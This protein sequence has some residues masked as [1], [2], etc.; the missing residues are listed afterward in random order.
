MQ[1]LVRISALVAAI[2]I[3]IIFGA[4]LDAQVSSSSGAIRG[5]VQ[6][7]NGNVIANAS[8]TLRNAQLSLT[9]EVKTDRDGT[10]AFPYL[11]PT[12][13]YRIT[14]EAP[15][16][17]RVQIDSLSARVTETT[18]A[19]VRLALGTVSEEVKVSATT[20]VVDTTSSTLGTVVNSRVITALP[21]PTRNV[22]D[23]LATDAGVTAALTS[24]A[25]TI[26]TSS[27]AI[28]VGGSRAT[29]NNFLF[30]GVDANSVEFNTLA[31]GTIAIP[32]ADS[33]QEFKTQTSLYDA[34]T[35]YSGGGNLNIVTRAGTKQHHGTVY[36]FLRNT[37]F[38][39][40]DYFLNA[41]NKPRPLLIQNQFGASAGGPI[42]HGHETFF[43]VNYEGLRQKN[44]VTGSVTGSQPV[45]PSTRDATSLA[46][47][48]GL[49]KSAIDPVAVNILNAQGPYGGYL[50]PSGTGSAVGTLGTYAYSSPVISNADQTSVRLD[51]EF[52]LGAQ[53][54]RLWGAFFYNKGLY[55]NP[56]GASG[57]LG[58]GYDYPLGNQNL[59]IN[60]T[61]VFSAH[62]VNDLVLGYTR[63]QRDIANYGTGVNVQDVGMYRANQSVFSLLPALS[64]TNALSLSGTTVGRYQRTANYDFRDTLSWLV[65]HHTLRIGGE[66]IHSQYNE[67][68]VP[69]TPL[70]TLAFSIGIANS[71]YGTSPLG[72]AGDLA[73]RDF[74]I[75][76][77]SSISSVSG[78]P[79]Y[80][81]RFSNYVGFV[82]DD[83]QAG[84]RLTLNLGVRYDHLGN[85]YET[86]NRFSNFDPSLLSASAAA[87]GGDSLKSAFVLAG[88]NGV[89][90]STYTAANHGSVSPR[91]GLVYDAYGD[92]Q[93]IVRAGFG[94]YY[95]A[96]TDAQTYMI[97]NPPYY[98][99]ATS[100]NTTR[101][102]IL[103]NP[104]QSLPT[105][106]QFPI[107]PTLPSI[108][109][110]SSSGVPIYSGTQIAAFS[111]DRRAKTPYTENWNFAVQ[112]RVLPQWYLEVG[113]RGANGV[114]QTNLSFNNNALL[115]N[116]ASPGLYNLTTNSSANRDAR[117][118]INGLGVNGLRSFTHSAFTSYNALLVTVTHPLSHNFQIKGAYTFSKSIS[119]YTVGVDA[120]YGTGVGNQY[121]LGANKGLSEQHSP[122]RLVVT[123]VWDTP[124]F[125][126]RPLRA[127]LGDWTLAGITTYQN[128]FA[129]TITQN[130]GTS[131]LTGSTGYGSLS[132]NCKLVASGRIEDHLTNYLNSSCA[133]TQPLLTAGSSI[134]GVNAYENKGTGNYTISSNGSGRLLG[135]STRGA[136]LAPFQ[137]RWDASLS[138]HFRTP[139]LGEGSD[140]ELRAEA[141]KLFNT[142]IFSAPAS[143]AGASTFGKITSTID[144]T[145]RQLQFALK[146]NY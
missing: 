30:N 113:Y 89:S 118:P 46:A 68:G 134:V 103:A 131:T 67:V 31:G 18:V 4:R 120:N 65:R 123:Y 135:K 55:I 66:F 91:V 116:S 130:S 27:N 125:Q 58:Q 144:T 94:L 57:S 92:G 45:L 114:K 52:Q 36:E 35:G 49:P 96:T 5:T 93:V 37:V 102:Q 70:G 19:N 54:N 22:F 109:G 95:Q 124:N 10:Y 129:Q 81:I 53:Q 75:G 78:V 107:W 44:G 83:Y 24:P 40:N 143:A 71:T 119:P 76:A 127:L 59:A 121:L 138:K 47:A 136:Y 141:F 122:H 50:F 69:A 73:F 82:Q 79:R 133:S 98:V 13:N 6:D 33:I 126:A 104:F 115:V 145:G 112:T 110:L 74:L 62:L 72:T 29:S 132:A 41:G 146:I 32:S 101:T 1:R 139:L 140:I 61:H 56:S 137:Q 39:A 3:S 7:P 85:P 63:I 8:V 106:D 100:S 108:T 25:T 87:A 48:F 12:S 64:F 80:H 105:P 43:F 11:V 86:N 111:A 26:V 16:F 42:P 28:Y 99:S 60:D 117:A 23:L 51:H 17:S 142:P 9:R 88:Q 21:L 128:G 2:A 14:V 15:G 34:T 97:M 90:R 84:P 77:P 38:N 20:D